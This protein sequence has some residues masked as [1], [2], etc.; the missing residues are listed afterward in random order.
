MGGTTAAAVQPPGVDSGW[1]V[2]VQAPSA[3]FTGTDGSVIAVGRPADSGNAD[4]VAFAPRGATRWRVRIAPCGT[5]NATTEAIR[6]PDGI[7]GPVGLR[8]TDPLGVDQSGALVAACGGAVAPTGACFE[9]LSYAGAPAV[10]RRSTWTTRLPEG[11]TNR[12][13]RLRV[14]PDGATLYVALGGSSAQLIA[15]DSIDGAVRWTANL[16]GDPVDIGIA[17]D[18]TIV[19]PERGQPELRGFT[20]AGLVAF[21]TV[22]PGLALAMVLDRHLGIAYVETG[23]GQYGGKVG[24]LSA[25][26]M[27]GSRHWAVIHGIGARPLSVGPNGIL[28]ISVVA[29][30]GAV[31]L[32]ALNP[33]GTER[34]TYPVPATSVGVPAFDRGRIVVSIGPW[35][36]R[37]NPR[38]AD[39]VAPAKARL[40]V[41]STRFRLT[42]PE[43]RC[44][45]RTKCNRT[46][47]FGAIVELQVPSSIGRIGR[48]SVSLRKTV[49]GPAIPAGQ[50]GLWSRPGSNW[51]QVTRAGNVAAPKPGPY[52]LTASWRDT[53]GVSKRLASP[54]TI[55]R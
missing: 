7:V 15:L 17:D 8:G 19:V 5:C 27:D 18:G 14:S 52:F 44:T 34:W 48:V 53:N 23:P 31:Y 26:G 37:L 33:N 45:T 40:T 47:P 21:H 49:N 10:Q 42:G 46:T 9:I 36:Y 6:S 51:I 2:P 25:F 22:L 24:T 12:D 29:G 1:P 28:Y 55:L 50:T 4:V 54:V 3:V 16:L 41:R 11:A 13:A 20:S 38:Q 39:P 30:P 32:R 43:Q 35:L